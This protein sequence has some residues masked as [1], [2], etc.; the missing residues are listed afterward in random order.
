M[1]NKIFKITSLICIFFICII[2]TSCKSNSV[3]DVELNSLYTR[4][5]DSREKFM[6]STAELKDE[7][8]TWDR[9]EDEGEKFTE[10]YRKN[11][12]DY[13]N[14][15]YEGDE[16]KYDKEG[17]LPRDKAIEDVE[18]LFRK[19]KFYYG[20][21]EYFG[22]D[23][24]FYKARDEI[25][26]EVKQCKELKC[27]DLAGII[28]EKLEFIKD[29]HLYIGDQAVAKEE[30][31]VHY[32][33]KDLFYKDKNRYYKKDGTNKIYIE[34]VDGDKNIDLYMKQHLTEEGKLVYRI[35]VEGPRQQD[36]TMKINI[37]YANGS[38]EKRTLSQFKP[39]N[40]G[41]YSFKVEDGIP[42]V[43]IPVMGR[44][45]EGEFAKTGEEMKK[46]PV[47][48]MDLRGNPGGYSEGVFKW[49]MNYTGVEPN[50]IGAFYSTESIMA[51]LQFEPDRWEWSELDFSTT[52]LKSRNKKVLPNKNK[53]FVLIDNDT[54]S[55]SELLVEQ[56]MTMENVVLVG[57]NTEGCIEHFGMLDLHLKNSKM[58]VYLGSYLYKS[59][60]GDVEFRGFQP[61]LFCAEDTLKAVKKF[62][63]IYENK[64]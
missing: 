19:F 35:T 15:K 22:G 24:V 44:Q 59:S 32:Y 18:D 23:K 30:Y 57:S 45:I 2:S 6:K 11:I 21:Y 27:D 4:I 48:I 25:L 55:A 42:V 52:A 28:C 8:I 47:S 53:L 33:G 51:D 34:A 9:G 7:Y 36:G 5:H 40:Q 16:F 61:D 54:G 14:N 37:T 26:N 60:Y 12:V 38:S 31:K 63:K 1:K 39:I 64:K 29:A 62:I 49:I 56:L 3:E 20:S 13:M 50:N 41:R 46:Y 58:P 10:E 17:M 43:T